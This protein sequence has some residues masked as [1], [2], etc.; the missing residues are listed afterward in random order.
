MSLLMV[1]NQTP[2][3]RLFSVISPVAMLASVTGTLFLSHRMG[4]S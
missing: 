1:A 3:I 4:I 2:L